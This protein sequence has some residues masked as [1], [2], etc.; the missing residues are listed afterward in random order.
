MLG[1]AT[2]LISVDRG[3]LFI[4]GMIAGASFHIIS[5]RTIE[6]DPK[7]ADVCDASI[8]PT[9][10]RHDDDGEDTPTSGSSITCKSDVVERSQDTQA[11]NT[12][13]ETSE[14]T[15]PVFGSNGGARRNRRNNGPN[16]GR[17]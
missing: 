17:R 10:V 13:T 16:N 3:V 6:K 7:K 1:V 5:N 8:G 4:I 11:E 2:G 9:W 15:K 12:D 14:S